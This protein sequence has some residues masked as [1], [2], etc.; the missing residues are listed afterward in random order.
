M[1]TEHCKGGLCTASWRMGGCECA[2]EQCS[3]A[4][5]VRP[6][7]SDLCPRCGHHTCDCD[8]MPKET[9][10]RAP[11][12]EQHLLLELGE[13]KRQLAEIK[14]VDGKMSLDYLRMVEQLHDATVERDD[15][16]IGLESA[17]A[18]IVA[19]QAFLAATENQ[20]QLFESQLT[21]VERERDRFIAERDTL[22]A[23]KESASTVLNGID[24][25]AVGKALG[26]PLGAD[27]GPAILPG[28]LSLAVANERMRKALIRLGTGDA[29]GMIYVRRIVCE[30]LECSP[31]SLDT[32]AT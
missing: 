18:E 4:M 32:E 28:I 9:F 2:C 15:A 13:L 16:R 12:N 17:R 3:E 26:L 25:Q 23:W 14:L 31:E 30:A 8:D 5:R 21:G 20:R 7:K 24:L 19:L 27:I 29:I 6:R 10:P 22:A 1:P 11:S